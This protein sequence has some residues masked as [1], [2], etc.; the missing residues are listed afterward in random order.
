M[1]RFFSRDPTDLMVLPSCC[2]NSRQMVSIELKPTIFGAKHMTYSVNDFIRSNDHHHSQI[3][4]RHDHTGHEFEWAISQGG[5]TVGGGCSI[6]P[7]ADR[8]I[9]ETELDREMRELTPIAKQAAI[10]FLR[11]NRS[12]TT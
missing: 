7:N 10:K 6:A 9:S 2:S 3:R 12:R 11:D 4:V 5:M 1:Q 8:L